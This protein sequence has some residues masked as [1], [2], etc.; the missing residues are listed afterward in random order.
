M[1]EP[2]QHKKEM[3]YVVPDSDAEMHVVGRFSQK[4]IKRVGNG[5]R[6][7]SIDQLVITDSK[8][9]TGFVRKE[10][11]LLLALFGRKIRIQ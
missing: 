8:T 5:L 11:G 9:R 10:R 6:S 1:V 7:C 2:L 3:V 4:T